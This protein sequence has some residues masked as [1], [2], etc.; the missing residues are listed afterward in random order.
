M[1]GLLVH[2]NQKSP[3]G[4]KKAPT[5]MGTL[6]TISIVIWMPW[7][8]CNSQ[9]L[10]RNWSSPILLQLTPET[11]MRV[12]Y[13]DSNTDNDSNGNAKEGK[14]ADSLVPTSLFLKCY[15][16]CFEEEI[17]HAVDERHIYGDQ[18]QDWFESQHEERPV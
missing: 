17:D 7:P 1:C 13:N 18:G 6:C 14:S 4:N 12:M 16:V 11:A 5:I 10:F 15:G 3:M 8:E 2:A 9:S